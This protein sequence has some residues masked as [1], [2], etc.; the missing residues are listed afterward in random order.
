MYVDVPAATATLGSPFVIA[1]WALNLAPAPALV[2]MRYTSGR[3]GGRRT[4][5]FFMGAPSQVTRPDVAAAYGPRFSA[6]G[7]M[8][9]GVLAPG[10]YDVVVFAQSTVT[11][12]FN[13]VVVLSI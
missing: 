1:G 6:C 4:A 2:S 8:L 11:G 3:T 10:A 13:N 9:L 7:F 5:E 12:T